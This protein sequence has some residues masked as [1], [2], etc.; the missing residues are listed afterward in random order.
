[1][2]VKKKLAWPIKTENWEMFSNLIDFVRDGKQNFPTMSCWSPNCTDG[3]VH[4][5]FQRIAFFMGSAGHNCMY[6]KWSVTRNVG[7]AYWTESESWLLQTS[8]YHWWRNTPSSLK[9]CYKFSLL[10]QQTCAG[11]SKLNMTSVLRLRITWHLTLWFSKIK[12]RI[13]QKK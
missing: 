7:T 12:L 4:L 13:Q 9:E 5:I 11:F 10:S 2:Q 6:N 1:M 3:A 8:G